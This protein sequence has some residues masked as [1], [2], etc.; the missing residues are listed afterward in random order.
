MRCN[1]VQRQLS[2]AF[3]DATHEVS[4]R[5]KQHLASCARCAHFVDTTTRT[6]ALLRHESDRLHLVPSESPGVPIAGGAATTSW[7]RPATIAVAVAASITI[8]TAIVTRDDSGPAINT[9]A[10]EFPVVRDGESVLLVWTSGGLP[11]GLRADVAAIDG[12]TGVTEVLGDHLALSARGGTLD[13]DVLAID[14]PSYASMVPP[15]ERNAFERLGGSDAIISRT[16]AALRDVRVDDRVELADGRSLRV[17]RVVDDEIVGAA[18]LVVATGSL[19]D[20]NTPRYLLV[21]FSGT[22]AAVEASIRLAIPAE[23]GVRFRTPDEAEILRHGDAVLP[24]SW[25]KRDFGEWIDTDPTAAIGLD[26]AFATN[27]ERFTV[28]HLGTV[29]CHLAI[30]DPLRLAIAALPPATAALLDDTTAVCFEPRGSATGGGPSRHTWGIAIDLD[31]ALHTKTEGQPPEGL[32]QA[33]TQAGFVWGGDWLDP[34][35][36]HFEWVGTRRAG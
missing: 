27:I 36:T 13:V 9:V 2:V 7:R 30:E 3:D 32:V 18:E 17:A 5:A 8:G 35:P 29:R 19:D 24:Q 11:R 1:A 33:F 34:D 15:S 23:L 26:P 31:I 21:R 25:I 22:R 14:P 6:R 16:S 20:V 28:D 10:G 12:V 4:S